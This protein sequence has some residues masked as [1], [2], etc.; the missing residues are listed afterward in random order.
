MSERNEERTV[1]MI[2]YQRER[3]GGDS[4]YTQK[5]KLKGTKRHAQGQT[6]R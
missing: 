2:K 6:G 5:D 1:V 4:T 3:G